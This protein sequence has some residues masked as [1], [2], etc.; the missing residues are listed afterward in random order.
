LLHDDSF[1]QKF[2]GVPQGT[3]SK[4]VTSARLITVDHAERAARYFKMRAEA[5]LDLG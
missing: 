1:R 2:L 5:F 3:V 4:I